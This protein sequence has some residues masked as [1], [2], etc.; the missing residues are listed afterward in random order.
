MDTIKPNYKKGY[1]ILLD[2]FD[3]IAEEEREAVHKQLLKVGL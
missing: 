3:S 1:Y 2:Y